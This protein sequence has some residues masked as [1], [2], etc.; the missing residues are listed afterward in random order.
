MGENTSDVHTQRC[1]SVKESI[2]QLF[3]QKVANDIFEINHKDDK[4]K[5]NV[6]VYITSPN[7]RSKKSSFI[8]FINSEYLRYMLR[9]L[10]SLSC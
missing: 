4:L 9:G 2:K 6:D 1:S 8:L 10:F 5:F 7:Y 3:G